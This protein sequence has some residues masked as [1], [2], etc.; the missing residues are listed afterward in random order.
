MS[1]HVTYPT[2]GRGSNNLNVLG[3]IISNDEDIL[4]DI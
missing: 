1:Q 4:G 2:R 3:L